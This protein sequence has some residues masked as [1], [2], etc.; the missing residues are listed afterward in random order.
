MDRKRADADSKRR[1]KRAEG[2]QLLRHSARVDKHPK[3]L[4]RTWPP[5][6]GYLHGKATRKFRIAIY[7]WRPSNRHEA[8]VLV[9]FVRY[10]SALLPAGIALFEIRIE[11]ARIRPTVWAFTDDAIET[12]STIRVNGGREVL[13]R[14]FRDRYR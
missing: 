13:P 9:E 7:T 11:D 14:R 10:V 3:A 4:G 2:E 6:F 12:V 1:S 5:L 8:T